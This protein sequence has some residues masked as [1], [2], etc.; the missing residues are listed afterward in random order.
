IRRVLEELMRATGVS[1]AQLARDKYRLRDALARRID[2]IRTAQRR[3]AYQAALFDGAAGTIE[4]SPDVA[5]V[6]GDPD[7]YAPNWYY[8]G[9]Y[10][11]RKH[12]LPNVGELGPDG[13]EHQ[14]AVHIDQHAEVEC[15]VR[16]L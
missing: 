10:R 9:A 15:W 14:C 16:N 2:A 4:V 3:T 11:F 13:E 7:R 6:L 1:L 12:L 8:E 5:L